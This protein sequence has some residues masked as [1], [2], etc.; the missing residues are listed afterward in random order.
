MN[1]LS[2]EKIFALHALIL[3]DGLDIEQYAM[4]FNQDPEEAKMLLYL[5]HE[6]GIITIR[7]DD[8]VV[9]PLLYRP[10]ISLLKSRNLLN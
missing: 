1:A 7:D 6:D 5:L 4:V 10:A 2:K 8:Y 9:N 3:H